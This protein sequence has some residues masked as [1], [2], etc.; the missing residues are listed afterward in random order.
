MSYSSGGIDPSYPT[1]DPSQGQ[2][3]QSFL[4]AAP[5]FWNRLATIGSSM[6]VAANA[7]GPGGFLPFGQNFAGPF[8]AG[9]AADQQ[10]QL[11]VANL[12]SSLAL[13]GAQTRGQ[14]LQNQITALGLPLAQMQAQLR[15]RF[16]SDP[17]FRQQFISSMGMGG[18]G[19]QPT[20]AWSG[21]CSEASGKWPGSTYHWL[22]AHNCAGC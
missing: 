4:G 13:R 8:G 14:Q 17:T 16:L 9:V 10:R 22:A 11:D 19:S 7:H 1:T 12:N 3:Q 21:R 18:S 20:A 6:A 5:D 15:Q 2:P